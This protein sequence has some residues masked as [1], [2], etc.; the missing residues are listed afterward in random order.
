M[1]TFSLRQGK[2]PTAKNYQKHHTSRLKLHRINHSWTIL[3]DVSPQILRRGQCTV[4]FIYTNDLALAIHNTAEHYISQFGQEAGH[5]FKEKCLLR[6]RDPPRTSYRTFYRTEESQVCTEPCGI[7]TKGTKKRS[8][9]SIATHSF[10][11]CA[12]FLKQRLQ[13]PFWVQ[14]HRVCNSNQYSINDIR[15]CC[16]S[17]FLILYFG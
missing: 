1:N 17:S 14:G 5:S 6:W 11:V 10:L 15:L 12:C 9:T 7:V 2:L 8:T 3:G 16:L 4:H 13:L